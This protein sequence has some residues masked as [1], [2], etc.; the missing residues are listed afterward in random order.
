MNILLVEDDVQTIQILSDFLHRIGHDVTCAKNGAEALE[1]Y[2]TKA[3]PMILSDIKMPGMSG[4]DLLKALKAE[5]ASEF[6]D[7]V[8]F[9]GYGSL[10]TAIEALR[11]GAYDYLL[12][13]IK[14]EELALLT[15]RVSE[16]QALKRENHLLTE[17]FSEQVER[18]TVYV[19]QEVIRLREIIA[20]TTNCGELGIFSASMRD[21]VEKANLYH[22]NRSMPVIIEGETG[23]GKE[24]IAKLI[25]HGEN[26]SARPF[27]DVNCAA[28]TS[29]LFESEL[30]GYEA[31]AFTGSLSKGQKGK[32]DLANGGTIFLDEVG[33][34]PIELQGKLLR[35]LQERSFYRVGGL[36]KVE[37][38]VRIIC[39]TNIDL[40][41]AIDRGKFR[42]DL[43]YRLN[44]LQI[45]LPPLRNRPESIV[46]LAQHFLNRFSR[47]KKKEFMSV[48]D[49]AAKA[50]LTYDWPG[51][52]RELKNVVERAVTL[53]N[54]TTL[55][56]SHLELPILDNKNKVPIIDIPWNLPNT[57]LSI[58]HL[59]DEIIQQAYKMHEYHI[60][61]TADYLGMT[62][63]MLAYRIKQIEGRDKGAL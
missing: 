43:F 54:D 45:K 60:G 16:H 39:A 56:C 63:R 24:L 6:T 31:G 20:T 55:R 14:P 61:K 47:E 29:S 50:L 41:S 58:D 21:A 34:I 30:F 10:E 35:F 19:K 44:T 7:I 2:N 59:M 46:P 27:I 37:V 49:D 36:K 28:L 25:H 12:K 17:K 26:K 57:P 62:R 3:F 18:E 48:G 33:E 13:P 40:V 32:L 42:R 15:D 52:V 38:D 53:Y 4:L 9:T 11:F 22:Q 23:T 5:K 8:L 51:N 1:L